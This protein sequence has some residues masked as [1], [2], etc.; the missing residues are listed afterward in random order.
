MLFKLKYLVA[1]TISTFKF[2]FGKKPEDGVRVL[3]F[4]S[5]NK[6][7]A[8]NVD[9]YTI[10][11]DLFEKQMA[12]LKRKNLKFSSF[13]NF[14]GN[15]SSIVLTFDDGFQDNFEVAK[16]LNE[17]KIP[18]T[19]FVVSDFVND[20]RGEYLTSDQ[21]KTLSLMEFVTIGAHGKT[22][23]PLTSLT[24]SEWKF[25][26]KESKEFLENI[27]GRK[28]SSMSFPHGRYTQEM[29]SYAQSLGIHKI[30]SSDIGTNYSGTGLIKRIFILNWDSLFLFQQKVLGHWDWM[31]KI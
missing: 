17:Q 13:E 1:I 24:E 14:N 26:I 19:I 8:Q 23:R 21:L 3:M 6:G 22:H 29:V 12:F 31:S 5:I 7:S 4:H 16:K 25:E 2:L 18:L 28:I 20:A 15:E 10:S 30:G 11:P 9:H 27:L